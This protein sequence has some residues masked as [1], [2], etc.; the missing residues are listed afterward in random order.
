M[1]NR[2]RAV[3]AALLA[4]VIALT[5]CSQSASALEKSAPDGGRQGNGGTEKTVRVSTVDEFLNAIAPDTNIVMQS[6]LY[7]LNT[8]ADYGRGSGEHYRWDEAYDGPELVIFNADNL[9]ITAAKDADVVISAVPRYA[10]VMRVVGCDN[11]LLDDVTLGHT[12]E[13]GACTGGV[14]RLESSDK[15]RINDCDLYGCGTVG[16][17]AYRCNELF[18][19]DCDIYECSYNAVAAASCRDVRIIDCDIHDIKSEWA[20]VFEVGQT[21]GFALVN[22]DIEKN[23][24]S[25][26]LYSYNSSEIY[27]LGC[28]TEENNF[29]SAVFSI[30]GKAPVIDG[31]SLKN[32]YF[33]A[34]Y[35]SSSDGGG[36]P[37]LRCVDRAGNE[38]TNAQLEAMR[39][40]DC[41]YDGPVISESAAKPNVTVSEN[42]EKSAHV[43]T[44]DEF[45]AAIQPDVNIIFET[46]TIDLSAAADYGSGSGEYYYWRDCYDGAELVITSVEGLSIASE[47][48]T[49]ITAAPR[50]AN[51]LNFENCTD[52]RLTG[53]T[54]GHTVEPGE[55][56]GGVL[57]FDG[58][59]NAA[60]DGC[61]LYG[62]GT[63]GIYASASNDLKVTGSEIF[64]CSVGAV[65]L[66][67]VDGAS[68]EDC[69]IHDCPRPEITLYECG[70]VFTNAAGESVEIKS[71]NY[72][73]N[74]DS[75]PISTDMDARVKVIFN[76][77]AV[78]SLKLGKDDAPV[79]LYAMVE[80]FD[81]GTVDAGRIRWSCAG[82]EDA[83][84]IDA[85]TGAAVTVR[86]NLASGESAELRIDYL[87]ENGNAACSASVLIT[88]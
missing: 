83:L 41:V 49:V 74:V 66:Y 72:T 58:C 61:S 18:V 65:L 6:G 78:E 4:A 11:F 43:K 57:A 45:L 46:D 8:A 87:D 23:S 36:T 20:N 75:L 39:Q 28:D 21:A 35:N 29:R 44:V 55:C 13:Q 85:D 76:G 69:S 22:C 64:D 37:G 17:D 12:K 31:T 30:S 40:S 71:G 47:I 80:L 34:W 59:I 52:L 33:T 73:L 88:G 42:G 19:T 86:S 82:S 9:S 25:H 84:S 32:N 70:A 62:C 54:A 67:G 56:A 24:V 81:G 15:A 60:V 50:Y 63:L 26:L 10:N 48:N 14:I 5:A 53:F 79:L 27:I 38:L 2:K 77:G 3:L 16:V 51:V 7:D 1:K 68:F